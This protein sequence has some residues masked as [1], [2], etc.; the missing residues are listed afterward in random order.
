[1]N[2]ALFPITA[3]L[4][5]LSGVGAPARLAEQ[6][7][8]ATALMK[9]ILGH[10]GIGP[11]PRQ[12]GLRQGLQRSLQ[13]FDGARLSFPALKAGV[14]CFDRFTVRGSGQP[15]AQRAIGRLGSGNRKPYRT[16]FG[17]VEGAYQPQGP[18]FTAALVLRG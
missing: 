2:L 17:F 15:W 10:G 1:M 4:L 14:S 9:A 6:R 11:A 12:R 18:P 13:R 16:R 5:L 3:L 7:G 8:S